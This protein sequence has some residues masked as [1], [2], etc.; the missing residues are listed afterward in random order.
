MCPTTTVKHVVLTAAFVLSSLT[1]AIAAEVHTGNSDA[2][3]QWFGRAGGL[4]GSDVVTQFKAQQETSQPVQVS[5]SPAVA[6]WTNMARGEAQ[7]GPVTD[8]FGHSKHPSAYSASAAPELYGR[9]G[10]DE[11]LEQIQ[12]SR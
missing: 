8:S 4:V 5:F 6:E 7:V 12:M 2:M 9:A 11:L 10:D 3:P 1:S